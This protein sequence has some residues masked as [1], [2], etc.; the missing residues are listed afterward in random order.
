MNGILSEKI[1]HG[2]DHKVY[3]ATHYKSTKDGLFSGGR[4]FSPSKDVDEQVKEDIL[5]KGFQIVQEEEFVDK[6]GR[7]C[8]QFFVI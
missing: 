4:V 6:E 5:S 2:K 8:A 1:Q 3:I 7:T